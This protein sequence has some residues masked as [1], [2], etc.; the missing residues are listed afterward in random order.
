MLEDDEVMVAVA[1]SRGSCSDHEG[2]QRHLRYLGQSWAR[3]LALGGRDD[4]LCHPDVSTY[5][6]IGVEHFRLSV[7]PRY[8]SSARV[9]TVCRDFAEMLADVKHQN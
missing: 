6:E 1:L 9:V 3:N 8:S 2:E 5:T 4:N 7:T